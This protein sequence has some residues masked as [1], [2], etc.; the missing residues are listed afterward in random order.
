MVYENYLNVIKLFFL[1][2][3]RILKKK[4]LMFIINDKWL[5]FGFYGVMY[6][7]FLEGLCDRFVFFWFYI[8]VKYWKDIF[9]NFVSVFF[10]VIFWFICWY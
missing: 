7:I 8:I 10:F 2:D 3:L 4:N 5:Y 1:R 6:I 9:V